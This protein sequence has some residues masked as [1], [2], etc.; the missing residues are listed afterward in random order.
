MKPI[1][2][3]KKVQLVGEWMRQIPDEYLAGVP[4]T[5]GNRS[6]KTTRAEV[7]RVL[8][9]PV[10]KGVRNLKLW[11]LHETEVDIQTTGFRRKSGSLQI[12]CTNFTPTQAKVIAQWAR[13]RTKVKK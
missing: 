12:G 9:A 2:I 10:G 13:G 5:R 1:I 6:R 8:A 3:G 11:V 7:R 4:W